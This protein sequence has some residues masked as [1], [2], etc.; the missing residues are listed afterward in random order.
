MF[1]DVFCMKTI[2]ARSCHEEMTTCKVVKGRQKVVKGELW[3]HFSFH[4]ERFT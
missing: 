4:N 1:S 2:Q 3:D